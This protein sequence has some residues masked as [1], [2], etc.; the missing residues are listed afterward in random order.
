MPWWHRVSD[1]DILFVISTD[2]GDHRAVSDWQR[3]AR[4]IAAGRSES[5]AWLGRDV[6]ICAS[7]GDRFT[8]SAPVATWAGKLPADLVH[9]WIASSVLAMAP[10]P[11]P[12]SGVRIHIPTAILSP[13]VQS[14]DTLRQRLRL[15]P[16]WAS[17]FPE[18]GGSSAIIERTRLADVLILA[19]GNLR[20]ATR[21]A[22]H[23]FGEFAKDVTC[24]SRLPLWDLRAAEDAQEALID[25]AEETRVQASSWEELRSMHDFQQAPTIHRE[26]RAVVIRSWIGVMWL[27]IAVELHARALQRPCR[28]PG[29]TEPMAKGARKYCVD[30]QPTM[31]RKNATERQRRARGGP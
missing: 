7:A 31:R 5:F 29:C 14:D 25:G 19:G 11:V 17:L 27:Q 18:D 10:I 22:E 24:P 2:H 16:A 4:K 21:A 12:G 9:Q 28:V 23:R 3:A 30:H 8:P 20:A 15:S 26:L 13:L 6:S 1:A